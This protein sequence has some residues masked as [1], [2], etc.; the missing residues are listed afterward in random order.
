MT[1]RRL[2][3][4]TRIRESLTRSSFRQLRGNGYPAVTHL[5]E[6]GALE[7]A[8]LLGDGLPGGED[9]VRQILV[10]ET[11]LEN[12]ARVVGLPEAVAQVRE[13]RGQTRR[14]LPVQ[15]TFDRLV[16]LLEALGEGGEQLQGELRASLYDLIE[17]RLPHHRHP[18]VGDRL[19]E[20]ILAGALLEAKL[21]ED[22]PLGQQ[23]GRGLLV[24]AVYLVQAHSALEQEVKVTIGIAGGVDDVPGSEAPRCHPNVCPLKIFEA[25]VSPTCGRRKG[26]GVV[27]DH[28]ECSPLETLNP[29]MIISRTSMSRACPGAI[30]LSD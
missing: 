14:Y 29:S 15:E 2:R 18:G 11:H 20:G 28:D 24:V 21:A 22:V 8:H 26:L 27:V 4:C 17:N 19:G 12:R 1:L 10:G 30:G 13:Q 23:R 16:G 7:P 3:C 25:K 6:T 5:D 9:H